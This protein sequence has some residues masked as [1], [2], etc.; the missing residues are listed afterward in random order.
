MYFITMASLLRYS[1][2]KTA[3]LA[4]TA[5]ALAAMTGCNAH[6]Y[7]NAELRLKTAFVFPPVYDT[8]ISP[9]NN[10]LIPIYKRIF[11]LKNDIDEL[12]ARLWAGGS[13][14]RIMKIDFNIDLLRKEV[15]A[16]SDIRRELLNTIY[17]IYPPYEHPEV[18]PYTGANKSYKKITKPIIL[19]TSEDQRNY[20]D[21]KSNEEKLSEEI[22]YRPLLASAL[23]KFDAL[24]DSLK[25]P[26]E[27]IG[28]PG[29]VP[30]IR[31]YTPPPLL[32]K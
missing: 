8:I 23:K 32:R 11:F 31:P 21:A 7:S 22:E 24:P 25:K 27:P 18:V 10:E 15:Y 1:T 2:L 26:I 14:Q 16:L 9:L 13:N 17:Y 30:R 29:P 3:A 19:V 12:K 6:R 28:T 4:L 5:A 20:L